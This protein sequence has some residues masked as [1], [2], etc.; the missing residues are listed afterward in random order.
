MKAQSNFNVRAASRLLDDVQAIVSTSAV[1][2]MTT[3]KLKAGRMEL[4]VHM[5]SKEAVRLRAGLKGAEIYE[6]AVSSQ[7]KAVHTPYPPRP[8]DEA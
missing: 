6:A 7:P 3:L 1:T 8:L 4:M 2:G 5:S